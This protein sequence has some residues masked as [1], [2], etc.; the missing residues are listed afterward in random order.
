MNPVSRLLLIA[1]VGLSVLTGAVLVVSSEDGVSSL[2]LN[3]G[4]VSATGRDGDSVK[5][6]LSEHSAKIAL[7]NNA[8]AVLSLDLIVD[9]GAGNRRDDGVTAGNVSGRGTKIALEVFA[10]GVTTTLR[11]L[12][13]RFDFDAS[14]VS[15][16]K[17][18]NSTFSL[19]LPEGSVGTALAATSPATLASSGFLARAEFET[20]VDVSGRAFSIGI[21]S[22]TLAENSTSSDVLRMSS[23]ISFNSAPSPDFDGDGT[24]GF[25]DFLTFAGAFGSSQGDGKYNAAQDLN[26]DGSIDFTDFLIFAGDFGS[27]VP[28]SGGGGTT[29]PPSGNPDLIVESPSVDDNTLTA[30]QSFT[31]NATVRNN[32]TGLA[33][34]S[35]LRYYRSDDATVSARDTEVGTDAVS[36][37]SAGATS[38]ESIRLNAPSSA[39]TYY[40]GACVDDVRGE[41]NTNNNCSSGVTTTVSG[42]GGGETV[43]IADDNLRAVIADSLGKPPDAPITREEMATL[44]RIWA[45]DSDISDL[46][47]LEF[48]A[49]LTQLLLGMPIGVP[50]YAINVA[51]QNSNT[52]SDLSPLSGLTNLT[53]LGL[54]GNAVS[55]VS[56]LAGVT[57]L[58]WLNLSHNAI[59]DVSALAGLINLTHLNLNNTVSDVSA[60][61]GL[62]NLTWLYLNDNSISNISAL[63][64]LT[65]LRFLFLANNNITNV[66]TLSGLTEL[67]YLSLLNNSLSDVSPLSGLTNLTDLELQNNSITELSPLSGLTNLTRLFLH[68]NSISDL[69]PLVANTG[70]GV[71]D[72][73]NLKVNPLSSTSRNTHIPTLQRRGVKVEFDGGTT[74]P[75]SNNPDL[76]VESPSVDDNTLTAG[77]SFTLSATIRNQGNALAAATTLRYYRSSNATIS[78]DDTEEGTGAVSALSAGATS[79]ESISLNAPSDAWTYYYGACIDDVSGESNTNN[80]C[81]SGVS[82]TVSGGGGG[83][84]GACRAGLVVN[85]GETCTYKGN[86]FSV[87]SS[88]RGSIAFFSAGTGIDARGTTVNGVRWN[89]HATKNSGSNSW[90][91]HVAD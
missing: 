65:K 42:G 44:T 16:V 36:T 13:L 29:T 33:A 81:S 84:G 27:Q 14:L 88:G 10:T 86:A 53:T 69:S 11:G 54:T 31:L 34:A 48:A 26:S 47:G 2:A 1:V 78:T 71:G 37:L 22:V 45:Q 4:G 59:F 55:D 90:T 30:G 87:S 20:V 80:N 91:I 43:T 79:A 64:G 57:N 66:S 35:T 74:P 7:G 39:G 60:L 83:S 76:I 24:V 3:A 49:N 46:T 23:E 58:R 5:G 15:F 73:V 12:I 28:P 17:A 52:V 56:A 41:S 32:G 19:S 63:S 9:G 61:A 25:S 89:F 82:V 8:N 77:Q 21:E 72:W 51:E 6:T 40:Y 68:S 85:P 67:T 62:S 75:P 70:L 38:A 18:E 50:Y